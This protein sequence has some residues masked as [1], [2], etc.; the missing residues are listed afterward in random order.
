M[1]PIGL[2][3]LKSNTAAVLNRAQQ[4]HVVITRG[5]KPCAV[6]IGVENYDKEDLELSR[7]SEFWTL[8]ES[9]RQGPMIPLAEVKR[10]LAKAKSRNGKV[11]RR[12]K[13]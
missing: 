5:G 2:K 13:A 8:I 7:S 10:R 3:E 9:R 11:R 4:E 1:K 12:N 6:V